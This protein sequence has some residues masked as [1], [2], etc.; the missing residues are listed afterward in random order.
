MTRKTAGEL[1]LKAKAD[2]TRYDLR[3][4]AEAALIDIPAQV[5]ECAKAHN[6]ILN[7][8]EYCIVLVRAGDPLISN[9][10]RK[11]IYAWLFL[12]DPRPEQAVFLYRKAD[13]SIRL[14]WSLPAAK[15]MAVISEMR[16]VAQQ[17]KSTKR[18]CDYFYTPNF[19]ERIRKEHGISLLSQREYLDANRE[20]LIKSGCQ[21]FDAS[22][23]DPFYF[24]KI[25]TDQLVDPA[26]ALTK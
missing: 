14:L 11:K 12:P 22:R 17:W 6:P 8:P 10:Q 15:T 18:W 26:V 3:E 24:S 21:H 9:L 13:D 2:E 25:L 7:E 20:E 5:Y 23:P 16:N 19:H 1:S 4:V